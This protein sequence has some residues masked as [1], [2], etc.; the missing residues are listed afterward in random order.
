MVESLKILHTGEQ[1]FREIM[2]CLAR[3]ER[4]VEIRCFVWRDDAT[5]NMAAREFL[6]AADRG[7]K[8]TIYKDRVG[9]IYEHFDPNMHSFLH[10]ELSLGDRFKLEF[11]CYVY[12][13]GRPRLQGF[14]P[15]AQQVVCHPN[16]TVLHEDK[17]HSH[18]KVFVFDDRTLFIGGMGIGDDFRSQWVDMMVRVEDAELVER[19]RQRLRGGLEAALEPPVDFLVNAWHN[20]GSQSFHVLETRLAAMQKLQKSLKMEMAYLGDKRINEALVALVERGIEVT[21]L[22]SSQANILN[23]LNLWTLDY[24]LRRTGNPPHLR[25][26][27]H[28]RMVHTKLMIFDETIVQIGSTN[29]TALS[30]DAFEETDLWVQDSDLAAQFSTLVEQHALEARRIRGHSPFDP[31]YGILEWLFQQSG[32][33]QKR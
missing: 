27:L 22:I 1:A 24:L 28:P 30:H 2:E 25:L 31:V 12:Y 11:L 23:D 26:F 33:Y 16:I 21:L 8:I 15:L 18:S 14:N 29:C 19:Y 5:G 32:W 4:D 20:D 9:S 17:L 3:A 7:I 13:H 6:K 10:K